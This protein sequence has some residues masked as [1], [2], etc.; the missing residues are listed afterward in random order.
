L[1]AWYATLRSGVHP[2]IAGVALGLLTPVGD[3]E[4]DAFA[5]L[6]TRLH[7]LS[8]YIVVPVFAL[9]NA[10]VSIDA[11]S[12]GGTTGSPI[13][14]GIVG[15]LVGGKLVG[16]AIPTLLALRSGFGGLP[17]RAGVREVVGVS[18][19]GGIGFTVAL[20]IASLAFDDPALVAIARTGVL[21]GSALSALV[22]VVL[23]WPEVPGQQSHGPRG[24]QR[25]AP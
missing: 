2:T 18:A 20:F 12:L 17:A 13:F 15:G 8:S 3:G 14:W 16:I 7:P 11:G 10:G 25:G 4:Q 24:G 19:L 23:L 9:A 1:L 6:E 22:G 21:C 5:A